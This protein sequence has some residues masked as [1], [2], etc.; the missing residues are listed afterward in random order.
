[1]EYTTQD[2]RVSNNQL[3]QLPEALGTLYNI[4]RVI[5]CVLYRT[6]L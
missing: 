4:Y 5:E 6:Y 2:L 1:M 3:A